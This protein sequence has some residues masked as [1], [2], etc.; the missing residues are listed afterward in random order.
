MTLVVRGGQQN[1]KQF[2][3]GSDLNL[4]SDPIMIPSGAVLRL[5]L[6]SGDEWHRCCRAIC[7]HT[8]LIFSLM[9][10]KILTCV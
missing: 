4:K 2:G 9:S 6:G 5:R 8:M 1:E 7:C 10:V 3:I